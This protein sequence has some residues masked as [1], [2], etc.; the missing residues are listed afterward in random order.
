SRRR[1]TRSKRDWS[2]DVCSSDLKTPCRNELVTAATPASAYTAPIPPGLPGPPLE[3][4]VENKAVLVTRTPEFNV[5]KPCCSGPVP[6]ERYIR[7]CPGLRFWNVSMFNVVASCPVST[8]IN[9]MLN[10]VPLSCVN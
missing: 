9:V 7:V 4:Y 8:S 5:P 6:V 2:S 1:H 10:G 3:V